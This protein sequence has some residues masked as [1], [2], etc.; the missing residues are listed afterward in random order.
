MSLMASR[1]L[2]YNPSSQDSEHGLPTKKRDKEV[3]LF[4]IRV[5]DRT[6]MVVIT[7]TVERRSNMREGR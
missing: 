3:D 6:E 5:V 2:C 1:L 4:E 7:G